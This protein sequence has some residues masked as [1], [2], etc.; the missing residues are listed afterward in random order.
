MYGDMHR[1]IP[2]LAHARGYLISE[3]DVE[4]HPRRSGLSKYGVGRFSRGF[5]DLVTVVFL[6]RFAQRPL[7]LFGLVG[8]AVILLGC[9]AL[10]GLHRNGVLLVCSVGVILFGI[11]LFVM[12]LLAELLV[13]F[14][15]RALS[16]YSIAERTGQEPESGPTA[17]VH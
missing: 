12:G 2:V 9:A 10:A 17:G 11:H 13:K 6:T 1:F 5:L 8:L 4:H 7:H 3:I 14:N 15:V 16:G